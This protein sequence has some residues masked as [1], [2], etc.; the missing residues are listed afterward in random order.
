MCT[1]HETRYTL[2]PQYW[3]LLWGF[4][5]W[6]ALEIPGK[7]Q[8]ADRDD[9]RAGAG[10]VGPRHPRH[11][12]RAHGGRRARW[13]QRSIQLVSPHFLWSAVNNCCAGAL[14]GQWANVFLCKASFVMMSPLFVD[15]SPLASWSM[16]SKAL[17][18]VAGWK[19][20]NGSTV[21]F[22]LRIHWPV[23]SICL[24]PNCIKV[25]LFF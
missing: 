8:L 22:M 1:F 4:S 21:N 23:K 11:T 12:R 7:V 15:D 20:L 6:F 18:T 2:R 14:S 9:R 24:G 10:Q 25:V 16:T 13:V 3:V 17:D 19:S 5:G